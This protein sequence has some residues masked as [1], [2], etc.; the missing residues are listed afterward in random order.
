MKGRSRIFVNL[1]PTI[2]ILV[3]IDA[4]DFLKLAAY[5]NVTTRKPL[6]KSLSFCHRRAAVQPFFHS[7]SV[8]SSSLS[9]AYSDLLLFWAAAISSR[10]RFRFRSRFLTC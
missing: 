5:T 7:L 2:A 3:V 10:I 8:S 6:E 4:T 1:L 9:S